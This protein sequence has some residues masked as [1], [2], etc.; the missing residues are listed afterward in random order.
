MFKGIFHKN[1]QNQRSDLVS[2]QDIFNRDIYLPPSFYLHLTEMDKIVQLVNFPVQWDKLCFTFV[3]HIPQESRQLKDHF[4]GPG[5]ILDRKSVNIIEI[6][7]QEMRVDL[8]FQKLQFAFLDRAL[9]V[10]HLALLFE[11]IPRKF[12]RTNNRDRWQT[13]QEIVK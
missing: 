9:E 10:F 5:R 8:R 13:S 4:R 2:R 11:K 12:E 1:H 3:Q 7:K 6:I